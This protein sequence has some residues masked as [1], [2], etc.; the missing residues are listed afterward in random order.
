MPPLRPTFGGG[1]KVRVL[2]ELVRRRHT[3][4]SLEHIVGEMLYFAIRDKQGLAKAGEALAASLT[5]TLGDG[6]LL[7]PAYPTAAP[8]HHTTMFTPF[9]CAY[10]NIINILRFPATSIPA[11]VDAR[12]LP[13]GLQA[14]AAH[15]RDELTI[16]AALALE[17]DLGGAPGLR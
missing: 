14:V 7:M 11:G 1:K 16:G 6:V 13:L 10:C 3:L 4:A 15:G 2:R 8:R 17:A 9:D 12:G 5:A